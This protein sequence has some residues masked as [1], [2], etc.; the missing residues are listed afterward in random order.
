MT[1]PNKLSLLNRYF[2]AISN[3]AVSLSLSNLPG[4]YN[5]YIKRNSEK[6]KSE[7]N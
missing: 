5:S 7:L 4:F 6:V 2:E 3:Q 1:K